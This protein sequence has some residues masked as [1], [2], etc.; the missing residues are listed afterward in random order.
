MIWFVVFHNRLPGQWWARKYGHVSLLGFSNKTW[1][2]LDLGYDKVEVGSHYAFEDVQHMLADYLSHTTV[3][4]FGP[5]YAPG[6]HFFHP[7]T[8]VSFVK[9]VLGLRS[10]ALLPDHL[11]S[12]LV[13]KHDVEIMNEVECS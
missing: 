11:F 5:A 4:K 13:A 7:M 6:R 1:V 10:R 9:Q 3:L 8:C 12:H 2:R